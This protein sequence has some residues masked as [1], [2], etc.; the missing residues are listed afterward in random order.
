LCTSLRWLGAA[1]DLS[2]RSRRLLVRVK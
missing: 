1:K 2:F